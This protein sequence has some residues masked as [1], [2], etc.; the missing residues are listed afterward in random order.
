MPRLARVLL[1]LAAAALAACG[2][3]REVRTQAPRPAVVVPDTAS[4][5]DR[6]ALAVTLVVADSMPADVTAL[7]LRVTALWLRP[8]GGDWQKRPVDRGAVESGGP[9]VRLLAADVPRRRYDSLAVVLAEPFVTF[10]PNAGGPLTLADSGLVRVPLVLDLL[11]RS[12]AD[13]RLRLDPAAS[14]ARD[15]TG[16]WRF[17]PRLA[18]SNTAQD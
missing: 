1:V 2:G 16:A 6:T 5:P 11:S 17:R 4:A 18:V 15:S 14:L 10:G 3:V 9:P 7:R 13:L 8:A 12:R